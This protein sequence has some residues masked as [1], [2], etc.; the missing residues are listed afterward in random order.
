MDARKVERELA[1]V[2]VKTV[3]GFEIRLPFSFLLFQNNGMLRGQINMYLPPEHPISAP[4]ILLN[5]L[6]S[7]YFLPVFLFCSLVQLVKSAIFV[8]FFPVLTHSILK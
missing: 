6:F 3:R 8:C 1:L 2:A 5:I 7:S 4:E